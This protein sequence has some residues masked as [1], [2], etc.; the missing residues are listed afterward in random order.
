MPSDTAALRISGHLNTEEGLYHNVTRD[1]DSYN[2]DAGVRARF[3]W[4]PTDNLTI[5]LIADS[6]ALGARWKMVLFFCAGI[7]AVVAHHSLYAFLHGKSVDDGPLSPFQS[8]FRTSM[9]DQALASALGNAIATIAKLCLAGAVATAFIQL[10]WWS[11]RRKGCTIRQVDKVM[12]YERRKTGSPMRILSVGMDSYLGSQDA[13]LPTSADLSRRGRDRPA[14]FTE[15]A[16]VSGGRSVQVKPDALTPTLRAIAEELRHQ[17]LL[18]FQPQRAW[19]CV[20]ASK[21]VQESGVTHARFGA[22]CILIVAEKGFHVTFWRL[23]DV[24]CLRPNVL[25]EWVGLRHGLCKVSSRN[26]RNDMAY[27]YLA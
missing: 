18:G 16:A 10:F 1:K 2:D 3:L 6:S 13:S 7:T 4:R 9:S 24:G 8:M 22:L 25:I 27:V 20:T 5:N 12:S 17:Y 21:A 15:L 19:P 26:A 23:W 14:L 11:M